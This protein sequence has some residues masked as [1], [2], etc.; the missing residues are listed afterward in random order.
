MNTAALFA[1]PVYRIALGNVV[2]IRGRA[3]RY[4]VVGIRTAASGPRCKLVALGGARAGSS[5]NE[6]S[7]DVLD[8]MDEPV[9]FFGALAT[10][11][12]HSAALLLE[13]AIGKSNMGVYLPLWSVR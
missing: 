3:R 8:R 10:R 1:L 5:P 6:L 12:Y 2:V 9:A 11:L 4:V 7:M 13:C